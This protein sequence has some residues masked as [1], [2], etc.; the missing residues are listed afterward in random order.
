MKELDYSDYL[1]WREA[2]IEHWTGNGL[3]C[4]EAEGL[5]D[6]YENDPYTVDADISITFDVSITDRIEEYGGFVSI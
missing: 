1:E 2:Q 6:E 4:D 5:M 3:D